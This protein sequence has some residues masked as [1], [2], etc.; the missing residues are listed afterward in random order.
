MVSTGAPESAAGL[1]VHAC[2][3]WP[4]LCTQ[5][6]A[7]LDATVSDPFDLPLVIVPG[8]AQRRSLRQAIA[9][10]GPGLPAGT[11]PGEGGICAGVD[12]TGMA[13]L[14]IR[15]EHDVL[16][17][18]TAADPWSAQ[19]LVVH[20]AAVMGQ[21]RGQDWF[22]LVQRH[23]DGHHSPPRPRPGRLVATARRFARLLAD[24]ARHCPQLLVRWESGDAVGVRGE[25]L[26]T[27]DRWQ[28]E[29]FAM[30][31][32]RLDGWPQPARRAALLNQTIRSGR[33]DPCLPPNLGVVSDRGFATAELDLLQAIS[34]RLPVPVWQL[35]LPVSGPRRCTL[36]R[37]Y[38]QLRDSAWSEW[39]HRATEICTADSDVLLDPAHGGRTSLLTAV[40]RD[41]AD[42]RAPGAPRTP[43]GS[44]QFHLSHGPDRQVE[45]LREL[46][47]ELFDT[48]PS[49][50][51]RDVVVACTDL[52]RY[53]PLLDAALGADPL[54]GLHPGHSLRA[55]LTTVH[56]ESN[57]VRELLLTLL[58]LPDRRASATE[59]LAFASNPVVARRFGLDEQALAELPRLLARAQV[60][61]GVDTAQRARNGLPSVRQGTWISG[62]DRLLAGLV[63]ADSPLARID[64]VVPV[65]HVDASDAAT[66]G[67]LAELVSRIRMHLMQCATPA[68][69]T[70]WQLRLARV[71]EDLT[72]PAIDEQWQ[73]NQVSSR[74][75]ELA[76]ACA[77]DTPLLDRGELAELLGGRLPQR[78]RPAV[79]GSGDLAVCGLD[80]LGQL[81]HRVVCLLG[82]D[83]AHTTAHASV[84]GDD[85][86]AR[87]GV[88]SSRPE[89]S[90][91]ARQDLLDALLGAQQRVII[92]GAGGDPLT[93]EPL[94][95]PVVVADLLDATGVPA[96][97]RRWPEPPAPPQH[98][99]APALMHWHG[100]QP[101]SPRNF[102][103]DERGRAHSFDEQALAGA[104]ALAASTRP[105]SQGANWELHA[106]SIPE[107]G[108]AVG[109]DELV[110]FYQDPASAWFRNTFGFL[111]SDADEPLAVDL[112]IELDGL[113][114]YSLGS[115][116]LDSL[117]AGEDAQAVSAAALLSGAAP[118]GPMGIQSV[119]AA[120]PTLQSMATTIAG[121]HREPHELDLGSGGA[122][123][124]VT[125]RLT[126][127]RDALVDHRY[128][129]V[130]AKD[131]VAA[132]IR[133]LC[134][135]AVSTV[136]R[137]AIVV[138]REQVHVLL[139]P[140]P[141]EAARLA[142][143]LVAVRRG[144]LASF[145]PLPP[146]AALRQARS[147]IEGDRRDWEIAREFDRETRFSVLWA[148]HLRLGWE[149]LSALPPHNEDPITDAASRFANL[150]RWLYVPLVRHWE[151]TPL[152][153]ALTDV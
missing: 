9:S 91:S 98:P 56:D 115:T 146:Q 17:L 69:M 108:E 101:H 130:R 150:S 72:E 39:S 133:L 129:R 25:P 20:L 103:P 62:L 38:G 79:F 24:Y 60:R 33:A 47:C 57:P 153:G 119:R 124:A 67:A 59:L 78:H 68:S 117:L 152:M 125:G 81:S 149:E 36:A 114:R 148:K 89:R 26:A 97:D 131:L 42:D 74:L 50:Q 137:R 52:T 66:I 110:H 121:L 105:A 147:W 128:G 28:A 93:G 85:L 40:Q 77:Q 136:V 45:V 49:L 140:E 100:L 96:A 113:E 35:G 8:A 138:G 10:A 12:M 16:G 3:D 43:D 58:A 4:V 92:I 53:A 65:N 95:E 142:E 141:D 6:S 2:R 63:L 118:P 48:D 88:T 1:H 99:E 54:P 76:Q 134:A 44:V 51:P 34:T 27:E 127:F 29:L 46:L 15:L 21:A 18:E 11:P 132:W 87:P 75:A 30:L 144:G 111:P 145:L 109:L 73:V 84:A 104:R 135:T 7:H 139:A 19:G 94:P 23:L 143:Q 80:E 31:V 106:G 71:M 126:C 37:R 22:A 122:G 120:L 70:Q 14:R 123:S 107:P 41:V 90:A 5:L 64:T 32:T 82:V 55:R 116:M 112:P 102:R 83:D 13:G 151:S 86:L 61:W